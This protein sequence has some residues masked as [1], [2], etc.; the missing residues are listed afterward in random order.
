M[1]VQGPSYLCQQ[2]QELSFIIK[3]SAAYMSFHHKAGETYH[4]EQNTDSGSEWALPILVLL[5]RGTRYIPAAGRPVHRRTRSSI[6]ASAPQ[7]PA[8]PVPLQTASR[9][10]RM[11]PGKG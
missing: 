5:T 6:L 9:R 8:A 10:S 7:T 11:S 4:T 3:C 2:M 1:R